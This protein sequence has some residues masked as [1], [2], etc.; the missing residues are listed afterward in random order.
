MRN[1]IFGYARV[2]TEAQNLDRQI[3]ALKKYGVDHIYHEK[4]TGT[5]KNRPELE[6]MLDRMT[7]GDQKTDPKIIKKA[8]K[9]YRTGQYSIKEVEELT[10]VKKSTLYRNLQADTNEER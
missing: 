1:Y 4:M 5:K 7:E 3:D 2:S 9:L 10:G 6:K 8:V